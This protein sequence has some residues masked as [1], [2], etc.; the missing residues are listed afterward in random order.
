MRLDN[1]IVPRQWDCGRWPAVCRQYEADGKAAVEQPSRLG[2]EIAHC[3]RRIGET[4]PLDDELWLRP[5]REIDDFDGGRVRHWQP[6][7]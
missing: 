6:H 1:N 5:E 4:T 2:Q 7:Q 3:F